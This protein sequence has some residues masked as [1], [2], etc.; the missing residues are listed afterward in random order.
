MNRL[1]QELRYAFRT[2][3]RGRFVAAL[4]VLAFAL[5]IGIT[6]AVFSIFNSVLLRPLPY[7]DSHELVFVFDT[8]PACRTCP[9]SHPSYI[10]WRDR[11][12]VFSAIG[13]STQASFVVTG[14]GAPDRLNGV[15]TTAS[16]VDVLGVRPFLGRWYSAEEDRPGGRKVIVLSHGYWTER[17]AA[18]PATLGQ[19]LV[20]DGEPYE[21]IGVMPEGFSYRNAAAF[22]PLAR[23]VDPN[24][25]RNHFLQ[26][27]A[28][29]KPGVSVEQAALEMRAL[30]QTLAREF[31]DN[32]GVDVR[33]YYEVIVGTIRTPLRVLLGAVFLVLLIAC[34]NVANLLLASGL[35]RRRELAIRLA[36]GA[37]P[38]DLARQLIAEAVVLASAGGILGVLLAMWGVRTFVVLAA[39]SL[40]R[41]AS[42]QIDGRVLAFT[43]GLSLLV[44]VICGIWPLIRLRTRALAAA[45]REGDLRTA[46]GSGGRFGNGLVMIEIAVAFALLVGASLLVKNLIL[47]QRRDAGI[48]TSR[49]VAFDVAPTGP[50]YA[51]PEQVR[52]FYRAMLERMAAV[53]GVESVGAVTQLPMYQFGVNTEVSIEGGTPW[54]ANEAP[55]VEQRR[56]G[57][58]YFETMGIRL[59]RG[60]MFSDVDGA[61]GQ[62]VVVIN[63]AMA[64]KFWPGQEAV[65]KRVRPGSSK[66]WLTVVGVIED[67]RSFGLS[68]TVPYEMYQTIEQQ[69]AAATTVV[70]RTQAEDPAAA[71]QAARQVVSSVDPTQPITMVQTME[72]VVSASVRQ[73]RLL[74]ALSGLFG[75]LAGLLAMVGVYGVT[76]Y[77]VRRQRREFGIR[78][79]LGA[80]A[81]AVRQLVVTRGAMTAAAGVALGSVAALLLTRTL[82]AMLHDVKPTDPLVF[83]G[84]AGAL[85][86]VSVAAS[87][88]PARA[89]GRVDPIVVLRDN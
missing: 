38:R 68:A 76:A 87:Y 73:P 30:G 51:N 33:S 3:I 35:A 20:L 25:R 42:V 15:A 2:T 81:R 17:F 12:T 62:P 8:Q 48:Q 5:G 59:V 63:R 83:I 70:M 14:T 19:R 27:A 37:G 67:V 18:N 85:L 39:N 75:A 64:G 77:N 22:V 13:G 86:A 52:A 4:A 69:P 40:P 82:Q 29:L 57:G 72:Q 79:A 78:L 88:L 26:T 60:R 9:A 53:G 84:T 10:D 58:R 71:V 11:N 43:A 61:A 7:P 49:I 23:K 34:A 80:D 50:R 28:R 45:V 24:T 55:L 6:T 65:G 21:V 74:S 1:V 56:I 47:L 54:N 31:G 46:S 32:H 16:L 41:A 66:T 44:G 36:L 89:A